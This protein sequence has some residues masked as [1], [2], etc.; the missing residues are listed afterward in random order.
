MYSKT[1]M[2]HFSMPLNIGVIDN[3]SAQCEVINEEGGCFDKVNFFV[4]FE[5][6]KIVDVKYRL[7]ACSG[8]IAAFSL[9]SEMVLNKSINELENITLE[10]M[11]EEIGGMPEKKMHSIRLAI[12]A[13]D[14]IVKLLKK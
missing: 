1:Y 12:E 9:L 4:K 13:K 7:K 11:T 8:T 2:K 14:E 10:S 6:D 3:P 5:N